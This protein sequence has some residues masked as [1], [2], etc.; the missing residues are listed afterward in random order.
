[1]SRWFHGFVDE[2]VKLSTSESA[3]DIDEAFREAKHEARVEPKD[4]ASI[5]SLRKNKSTP[6]RYLASMM[7]GALATPVLT[8]AGK[9]ISRAFHNKAVRRALAETVSPKKRR[10]LK[11]ELQ[12]GKLVGRA[13][14]G[15]P[16]SERPLVSTSDVVSDAARGAIGGSVLQMIRDRF[17]Q[18]RNE[19]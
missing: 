8:I 16:L 3:T 10:L 11:E 5:R 15:R 9:G 4:E 19:H 17:T 12:V 13:L 18:P 6:R 1:M 14:P 2:L 7:I